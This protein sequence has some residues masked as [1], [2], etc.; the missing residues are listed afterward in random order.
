MAE[1]DYFDHA[2][3]DGGSAA[4]RATREGYRWQRGRREHRRRARAPEQ[5]VAGWLAS[6]G[7]CA[8]IMAPG[9]A[10]TG[11]AYAIDPQAELAIYWTQVLGAR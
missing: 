9:F 11:A 2:A 4:Q 3:P 7:H 8:N 10:E 5:V 6:P 1:H